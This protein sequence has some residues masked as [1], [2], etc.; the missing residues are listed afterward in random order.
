MTVDDLFATSSYGSLSISPDGRW[1]AFTL[2]RA[3]EKTNRWEADLWRLDLKDPQ[4]E[5]V[6]LTRG[7]GSVSQLA[8]SPDNRWIGF[9]MNRG[10][11]DA[12]DQ[13][14]RIAPDGG[15]AEV[16]TE[17]KPGVEGFAWAGAGH[18]L[19][20][21]QEPKTLRE[22]ELEK[23]KDDTDVVEDRK[24]WPAV[25]LFTL[26]LGKK[27]VRRVTA[28]DDRIDGLW[29]REDGDAWVTRHITSITWE[30]QPGG[31][32]PQYFLHENES[33]REIFR[34]P[35]FY[36]SRLAFTPSGEL[37]AQYSY[38]RRTTEQYRSEASIETLWKVDPKTDER[39]RI[40][41]GEMGLDQHLR[42]S[43]WQVTRKGILAVMADRVHGRPVW[44][45]RT[46]GKWKI[47]DLRGPR[48]PRWL[49][50]SIDRGGKR[51]AWIYSSAG[52]P[53]RLST[54]ILRGTRVKHER[55]AQNLNEKL[56]KKTGRSQTVH[57]KSSLDGTEITGIL[58]LP[59]NDGEKR[60]FPMM[61]WMH[62]G[63]TGVDAD[64]FE[65]YWASFPHVL[66]GMGI[67]TL[68]PNYRGSINHGLDYVEAITNG[69]YYEL[70][71]PDILDGIDAMIARGIA[72]PDS[73]GCIG[74]SNGSI[75]SIAL[76]V[77]T[78]R[79]KVCC[80]GAGDVNWTS[81]FGNCAFGPNF[82]VGYF[83]DTPWGNPQLYLEKSPLFQMEKVTTP[84]LI[85]FGE[86]DTNVPTSQGWEHYRALQLIG[87]APVRFLLYPGM[88]HGLRKL[89]YQ[90]RKANEEIAWISR[91][92]LGKTAGDDEVI[93]EGSPLACALARDDM[94]DPE[95]GSMG[96]R[97]GDLLLPPLGKTPLESG[98]RLAS[99][100]LT[101]AML[102]PALKDPHL[103]ELS[104]GLCGDSEDLKAYASEG[105]LPATGMS[106]PLAEAYVQWLSE[107]TG[108]HWRLPHRD[109]L[110]QALEMIEP[111][112]GEN[113]LSR[114][115]GYEPTYDEARALRKRMLAAGNPAR[116]LLPVA[117][118]GAHRLGN[119]G[120]SGATG[121]R[122]W[123]DLH[124][125]AAEWSVDSQG[126]GVVF[127]RSVLDPAA[128]GSFSPD[129]ALGPVPPELVGVRL[130]LDPSEQD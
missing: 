9:V 92:L 52:E 41:E 91:Y 94:I 24:H 77:K 127:G 75:L 59:R 73:L 26:D 31:P 21:A 46:G 130:A 45:Q 103:S 109:E 39:M 36:P 23:K 99:V 87:K 126:K 97:R 58:T 14:W 76:T 122:Y 35:T 51:L 124:G 83:G 64:N 20:Y 79:F 62:G 82:D 128:M 125:N 120:K 115:A 98:V 72:H 8:W 86:K 32:W 112:P 1:L 7:E 55:L 119:A 108:Q 53:E 118:G 61:V 43:S 111:A 106:F 95:T 90:R 19:F 93:K 114:W 96:R 2:R 47:Q 101:R 15:E 69:K 63:P 44:I 12:K 60:A 57:W 16:L 17:W 67:A 42:G 6:R 80:A 5:A 123:Y 121:S 85:Q 71:I 30:S 65:N 89:S 74:W 113:T 88:P 38:S 54:G 117:S 129:R 105:D 66:A 4:A 33:E 13:V 102:A 48:L 104:D 110:E 27:K 116:W 34:D 100:E 68:Q 25:R 28:N 40:D 56:E 18:L 49:M 3:N 107:K 84:T 10:G 50:V 81:D 78:D 22:R 29:V 37:I 11:K 70:E